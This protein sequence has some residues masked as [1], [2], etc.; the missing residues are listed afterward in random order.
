M[1]IIVKSIYRHP[2]KGLTPEEIN[3]VRLMPG[4]GIPNDRRFALALG[5]AAKATASTTWMPKSN[6]LTLQRNEILAQLETR[7]DDKTET[8]CI[9]RRGHQ[10]AQGK[11]TDRAGRSSIEDFFGALV[12]DSAKRQPKIVEAAGSHSLSD[13][14]SPVISI[15]NLSSVKDLER[16]T[17]KTVDPMRFRANI[18]LEGIEPWFEFRW[19]K[20]RIKVGAV[21][22]TV[23]DRIDRCAAINVNPKTG[24][25]DQN[26][27][28]SIKAGYCHSD[29]GVYAKVETSGIINIGDTVCLPT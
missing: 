11:L 23:Q 7:F 27:V 3:A 15:L 2:V 16:V 18:W 26:L 8:F 29:F 4:Y 22:L 21:Y 12:K 25:R 6:F 14:G 17:Q 1:S 13:H 28:K 5:S 20:K 24:L 10:V 9:F 19:I